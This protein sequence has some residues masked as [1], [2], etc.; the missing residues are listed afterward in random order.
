[1]NRN[2]IETCLIIYVQDIDCQARNIR[3]NYR[4]NYVQHYAVNTGHSWINI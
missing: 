3:K 2:K 1:M 4:L